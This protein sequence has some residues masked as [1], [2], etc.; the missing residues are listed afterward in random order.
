MTNPLILIATTFLSATFGLA[1]FYF[2][3]QYLIS[4][5]N[6]DKNFVSV[7]W[8]LLLLGTAICFAGM[9]LVYGSKVFIMIT[10][11]EI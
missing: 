1:S 5:R 11:G 6:K 9:T 4:L 7:S 8:F 10:G 3:E 2:A